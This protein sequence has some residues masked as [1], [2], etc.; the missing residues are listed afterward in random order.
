MPECVPVER[1]PLVVGPVVCVTGCLDQSVDDGGRMSLTSDKG[2][3]KRQ[4][5]DGGGV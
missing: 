4:L 3:V 1:V 5:A 2:T